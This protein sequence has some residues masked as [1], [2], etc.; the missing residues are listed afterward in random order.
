MASFHIYTCARSSDVNILERNLRRSPAIANGDI[1]LTVLWNRPSAA[2][3]Y[4]NAIKTASA[5]IL[6]FAHCDV[7]FPDHWFERLDWEVDRLTRLDARWAVA[8]ISGV[9][10]DGE[11]VGRTWDCSLA[12]WF[13]ETAGLYGK[14]LKRPVPIVSLDEMVIVVRR[15]AG[16]SFDP[17]LPEFHLYGTDIALEARRLGKSCYGL[18]MPLIHNAK[19]QLRL[20]PD[21]IRSYRYM[22]RKWRDRLP[23]P[24]TCGLLTQ[25]PFVLPMRR[26]RIRY[27]AIFRTSTYST[28]RLSD[29]S[30]KARE[31]GMDRL[32]AAPMENSSAHDV[33]GGSR[34]E[35]GPSSASKTPEE[36]NQR[37]MPSTG[38]FR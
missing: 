24:T 28:Q 18:D 20:G 22:V 29:P 10:P 7:Y 27:K 30:V 2:S 37:Q 8:G 13:P 23:V 36:S 33:R 21:Y 15:E 38:L 6:V 31:L 16:V 4:A 1:D 26:L 11:V 3:A 12:P 35:V 25:N 34:A 17:L 5:E 32:L 14:E 19:A 9:A